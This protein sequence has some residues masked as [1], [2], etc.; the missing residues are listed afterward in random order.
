MRRKGSRQREDTQSIVVES[1]IE[2]GEKSE[3]E[4]LHKK[5]C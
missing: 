1:C 5:K 2:D 3:E 4:E